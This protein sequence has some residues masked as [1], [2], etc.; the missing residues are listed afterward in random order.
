M[1]FI[2]DD[3]RSSFLSADHRTAR[4]PHGCDDCPGT[5]A[6]G[7][8]YTRR[9]WAVDGRIWTANECA[10]CERVRALIKAHEIA[11]GCAAW[12]A[13]APFGGDSLSGWMADRDLRYDAAADALVSS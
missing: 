3:G 8:P 2:D 7:Q 9:S 10:R 1:C 11:E 6:S 13:V 5:I 4:K 12:E